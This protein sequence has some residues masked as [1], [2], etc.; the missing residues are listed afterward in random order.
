MVVARTVGR[1]IDGGTEDKSFSML[2]QTKLAHLNATDAT[3]ISA[4][5]P[6][7]SLLYR[8]AGPLVVDR[9]GTSVGRFQLVPDCRNANYLPEIERQSLSSRFPTQSAFLLDLRTL[10]RTEGQEKETIAGMVSH[11]LASCWC[12]VIDVYRS[13]FEFNEIRTNVIRTPTN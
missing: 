2:P 1:L 9:P 8:L 12:A 5:S 10:T 3:V 11:I 7:L 13:L 4:P 6:R